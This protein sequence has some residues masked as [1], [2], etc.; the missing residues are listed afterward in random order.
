M[1]DFGVAGRWRTIDC[2]DMEARVTDAVEGPGAADEY[3]QAFAAVRRHYREHG[4]D[5]K[6]GWR[7]R[8]SIPLSIFLMHE[9]EKPGCWKDKRFLAE[10]EKLWGVLPKGSTGWFS[11]AGLVQNSRPSTWT[12]EDSRTRTSSTTSPSLRGPSQTNASG[13]SLLVTS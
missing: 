4:V 2:E 5:R 12:A 9:R 13:S 10:Q 11:G 3:R 7:H 1:S 6:S 8:M